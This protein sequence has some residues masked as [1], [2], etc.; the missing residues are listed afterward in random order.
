[1]SDT[2]L[3]L[4]PCDPYFVPSPEAQATAKTVLTYAVSSWE[5]TAQVTDKVEIIHPMDRFGDITCHLC[6]SPIDKDWW[7]MALNRL[8]DLETGFS[9][10]DIVTPCCG[11]PSSLRDLDYGVDPVGFARF[12]LLALYFARGLSSS[13]LSL[14]ELILGFPLRKAVIRY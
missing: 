3:C 1:M 5:V 7:Y 10:T 12:Q 6:E 13:E 11:K 8:Y 2:F 9:N 14:F 4:F